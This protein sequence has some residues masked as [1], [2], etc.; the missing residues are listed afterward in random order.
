VAEGS[1]LEN[2][3]GGNST[4]G[5]NPTPSANLSMFSE[6]FKELSQKP[7]RCS[8]NCR[9]LVAFDGGLRSLAP[10]VETPLEDCG[11]NGI[12]WA[13]RRVAAGHDR[14]DWSSG[15]HMTMSHPFGACRAGLRPLHEEGGQRFLP[16][17][18]AVFE[19]PHRQ[20][21][22]T[23]F[24]GR[25]A[26]LASHRA[27][28]PSS[29]ILT[30]SAGVI[31]MVARRINVTFSPS[32]RSTRPRVS[33]QLLT[34]PYPQSVRPTGDDGARFIATALRSQTVKFSA[35]DAPLCWGSSTPPARLKTRTE[36]DRQ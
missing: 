35:L 7:T 8:T 6:A 31:R 28:F 29:T 9:L 24:S 4:V 32:A 16:A 27:W 5:S 15:H 20:S 33:S 25:Q 14:H 13:V 17:P 36:F 34:R 3:R 26:K 22:G 23:P 21:L 18:Q 2:R 12:A 30:A 1:G 19:H 10:A 11:S